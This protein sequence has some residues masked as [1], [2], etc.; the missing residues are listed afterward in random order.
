MVVWRRRHSQLVVCGGRNPVYGV[1]PRRGLRHQVRGVMRFFGGAPSAPT[2]RASAGGET[3]SILL[4]V[5]SQERAPGELKGMGN[6]ILLCAF[7]GG[8]VTLF[9]GTPRCVPVKTETR[10][11]TIYYLWR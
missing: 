2:F 3:H 4:D 11:I 8:R 7:M 6:I 10:D 1:A 9:F 5:T